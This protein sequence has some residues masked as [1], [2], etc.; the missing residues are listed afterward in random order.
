[1]FLSIVIF[2]KKASRSRLPAALRE[3]RLPGRGRRP[4]LD[5]TTWP[6]TALFTRFSI[7]GI[8][9]WLKLARWVNDIGFLRSCDR[10]G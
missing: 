3:A 8:L 9:K 1:M 6:R 10:E 2:Q 7:K 5:Y 4:D